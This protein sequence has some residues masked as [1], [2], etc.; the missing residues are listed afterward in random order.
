MIVLTLCSV[1]S[2]R[3]AQAKPPA[4]QAKASYRVVGYFLDRGDAASLRAL[5]H[6][7]PAKLTD[8]YYAFGI[9]R[10]GEL[11]LGD[12]VPADKVKASFAAMAKLKHSNPHLQILVSVGGWSDSD[13]FSDTALTAESRAKFA[14]SAVAFVRRHHLD[15]IDIDWEFPVSGGENPDA[16]RPE[17][18]Q[19]YTL[20]LQALRDK[21]DLAAKQDKHRYLLTAAVG[22]NEQFLFNT[23]MDKVAHIVDW[24]NVMTYDFNGHWNTYAG[25]VAPLYDDPTLK[26]A[27][28]SPKNNIDSVVALFLR[29]GLPADK[30]VLG[31]PFYGYSWKQCGASNNGQLQDCR[32]KGRGS[33]EDGELQFTDIDAGLVNKKGFV[34][35]WNDKAKVPYLFNTDTG[36]FISYDDLESLDYKIKYLKT[37]RLG[38]AMFWE[39]AGDRNFVLQNKLAHDLLA[40]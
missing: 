21:L 28:N 5:Q 9:I 24:A 17:D 1:L 13:K 34:R 32:G 23:E 39:L 35:H 6:V 2:S 22:N 10:D 4:K 7:H 8:L 12:R 19:N 11:A 38:G 36:E 31:V 25:H 26:H 33:F 3:W 27:G 14:E 18:K 29:A 37:H 20:F 15:G 16:R 30:L 40:R